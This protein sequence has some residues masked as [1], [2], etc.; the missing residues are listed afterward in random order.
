MS[1]NLELSIGEF[2]HLY[3]RGVE[4]RRIFLDKKDHLRFIVLLYVVNGT[5]TIHLSNYQSTKTNFF[6]LPRGETLIDIGAYCLMPN[7]FHLL[8][9]EKNENG[10]SLFMQRLL[11]AYTMY[12]NKKYS[13]TGVLFEGTFKAAHA[14]E[15]QY[16]KYLF[17]YIH[18]NPIKMFE[19][20]WKEKG[21]KNKK[22]AERFLSSFQYSSYLDYAG[23]ERGQKVILNRSA[24]P[25]YFG[26]L[27]SVKAVTHEWLNSHG[28]SR[29]G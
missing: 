13:R 4:K 14:D 17:S 12:F 8:I 24:F 16:L 18:L 3:N 7:H 25:E 10:T 11:T 15:D 20:H 21:I 6:L 27:N 19:P 28:N 26:M 29:Q 2:Y 5:T 23:K 22:R 1:R 9:R